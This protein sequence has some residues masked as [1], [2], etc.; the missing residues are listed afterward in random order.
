MNKEYC[1]SC[2]KPVPTNCVPEYVDLWTSLGVE[3]SQ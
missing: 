2:P 3:V 1:A